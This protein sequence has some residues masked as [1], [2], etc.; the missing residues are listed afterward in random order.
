MLWVER[1]L[2]RS[3]SS[4]PQEYGCVLHSCSVQFIVLLTFEQFSHFNPKE[5]D[6]RRIIHLLHYFKKKKKKGGGII[7]QKYMVL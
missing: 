1:D 3:S 5:R 2:L 7:L 4:N 6:H